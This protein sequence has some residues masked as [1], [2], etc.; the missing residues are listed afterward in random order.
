MNFDTPNH[1]V[2]KG[3]ADNVHNTKTVTKFFI[4]LWCGLI[5]AL[6]TFPGLRVARMHW[7][8]L[9][10]GESSVRAVLLHIGFILPLILTTFWV[11][12][13]TRDP[14][15]VKIYRNMSTPLMTEDE[16]ESLRLYLIMF[17]VLYRLFIMPTYLQVV[18]I[19]QSDLHER[20]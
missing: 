4:A 19:H 20:P 9:K 1:T 12:P 10:Y 6:F 3:S 15:T 14:L 8:S 7:D 18:F 11:R 5:G 17:T 2:S 13:L 16:F